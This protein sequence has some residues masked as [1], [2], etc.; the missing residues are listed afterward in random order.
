MGDTSPRHLSLVAVI[1]LVAMRIGI[2]LHFSV[3]GLNKWIDRK[4]FVE[5]FL[6]NSVGPFAPLFQ[7][8][9]WDADG[10]ARMNLK[11][12]Q[13]IW[14][15]Y[16]EQ[17]I[18][19]FG[20]NERQ[21]KQAQLIQD[22]REQQLKAHLAEYADDV[23]Q[24]KK[25]LQRRDA[26]RRERARVEVASLREQLQ[27][28]EQELSAKRTELLGPIHQIWGGYRNDLIALG[29][30]VQPQR[31]GLTLPKP[32]RRWLDSETIDVIIRYFD[33]AVGVFL[34]CGIFTRI[35]AL[36]GAAFLVSIMSS[37]WPWA[38][39]AV[40][41]WYQFVETLGLLVLATTAAGYFAGFDYLLAPLCKWC[42]PIRKGTPA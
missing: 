10:L 23:S 6:R 28:I 25:G 15:R 36:A 21:A 2:G 19:H 4:P 29:Q 22:R 40:P 30:S 26:Y 16:R 37:Q 18:K 5:P 7:S 38:P 41:I 34:I 35:A 14:D 33:V 12:T 24:Y 32:G 17:T 8:F 3:E 20:L 31:A 1:A 11:E 42:C 9:V 39:G 27:S 13:A